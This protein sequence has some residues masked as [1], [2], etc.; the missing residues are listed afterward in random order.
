MIREHDSELYYVGVGECGL[1]PFLRT[2]DGIF[3]YRVYNMLLDQ[4]F[5]RTWL[6]GPAMFS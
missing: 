3:A 1:K 2:L 4:G 5:T 6:V